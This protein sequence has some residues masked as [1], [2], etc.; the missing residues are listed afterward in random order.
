M[1]PCL[2]LQNGLLVRSEEFKTHQVMGNPIHQ[3]ERFSAWAVDEL[4]YLDITREGVHDL[5]RDD[6]KVKGSADI[7]E[8]V[9]AISR[10]LLRAADVRRRDPDARG[11]PPADRPRRRQGR[12]QHAGRRRARRSSSEAAG[13]FG[14]QA[15][16]VSID[17]SERD[18]GWEVM[19]RWGA[20]RHRARRRRVGARGRAAR[21]GRDLPEL[22]RPRRDGQR[23]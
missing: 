11:R 5:R 14:S 15:I 7:L 6:Q 8:I 21:R 2:L 20:P 16:V 22:G 13:V 4:V 18:G 19:T 23:L 10:T 17:A 12:D 3:V 9:E 1:I